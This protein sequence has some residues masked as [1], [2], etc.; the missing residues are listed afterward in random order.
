MSTNRPPLPVFHLEDVTQNDIDHAYAFVPEYRALNQRPV[1]HIIRAIHSIRHLQRNAEPGRTVV[2]LGRSNWK[3]VRRRFDEHRRD[4]H[5]S[6][7][8]VLLQTP[9]TQIEDFEAVGI[10]M[11]KAL[12]SR[13][14]LC[15][16]NIHP[17]ARGY[18]APGPAVVYMTWKLEPTAVDLRKPR[19]EEKDEIA[20]EVEA[21]TGGAIER[22][23]IRTALRRVQ[24]ASLPNALA[25]T[26]RYRREGSFRRYSAW[27]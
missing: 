24:S 12:A 25:W 9:R 20:D 17:D 2:Y 14:V 6:F 8:A 4:K 1:A 23:A 7:G 11:L 19:P 16:Q 10:A 5:H 3:N 13:G 21:A 27:S 18:I 22:Y 26:A 15:V